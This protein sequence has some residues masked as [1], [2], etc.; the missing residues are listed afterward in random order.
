MNAQAGAT[1]R[2]A[3]LSDTGAVREHNEDNYWFFGHVMPA[4]HQS[5]E[6]LFAE[7]PLERPFIV[8]LFDGMGGEAGGEVASHAA[9]EVLGG[10]S[11]VG[12]WTEESVRS[13]VAAMNEAVRAEQESLRMPG[14]G[15]TA[16]LL[17]SAGDGS[18][19]VANLGD[20]PALLCSDGVVE[21]LSVADTDAATF[22]QLGIEN[23]KPGLT[24]YLG[25]SEE[26]LVLDPHVSRVSLA[27][28][29]V[30]V[31]AS[32]GLTDV[33]A[34]AAIAEVLSSAAG[35]REKVVRLRN[36]AL[37]CGSTDNITV[38][39]CERPRDA[40]PDAASPLGAKG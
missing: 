37:E 1:L 9:A 27:P 5:A 33:V 26:G 38:I 34:E 39:L 30:I 31:L 19:L 28:G 25:I 24:Q 8:G 2:L 40:R 35:T 32:D 18:M 6:P 4:E 15:T 13:V 17:A 11:E 14:M 20:S 3:C 7:I 36:M 10:R 21:A 16:T 22:L 23:R 29:G 12:T